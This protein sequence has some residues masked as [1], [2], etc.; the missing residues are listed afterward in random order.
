MKMG[1][2]E[3][4]KRYAHEKYGTVWLEHVVPECSGTYSNICIVSDV[5]NELRLVFEHD[6][7]EV[8]E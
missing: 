6:L 3:T 8:E 4:G 5:E 7:K 1:K 2:L